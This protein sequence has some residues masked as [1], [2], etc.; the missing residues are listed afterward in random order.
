MKLHKKNKNPRDKKIAFR[1]DKKI[2]DSECSRSENYYTSFKIECENLPYRT[3]GGYDPKNE[4]VVDHRNKQIGL[5]LDV[6]ED[7]KYIIFS[8]VIQKNIPIGSKI[9]IDER[10][11]VFGTVSRHFEGFYSA[12][13][14]DVRNIQKGQK[15]HET[16]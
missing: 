12:R 7:H 11:K 5:V 14:D 3:G 8:S 4:G 16:Q 6:K 1:N 15:I 10:A 9:I 13:V 2:E